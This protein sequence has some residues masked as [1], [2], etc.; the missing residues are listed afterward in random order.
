MNWTDSPAVMR[1]ANATSPFS[2]TG[3]LGTGQSA[4]SSRACKLADEFDIPLY[5]RKM[6][7]INLI[8]KYKFEVLAILNGGRIPEFKYPIGFDFV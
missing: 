7:D 3:K 6:G 5:N 4:I 2:A 1:Y 8:D